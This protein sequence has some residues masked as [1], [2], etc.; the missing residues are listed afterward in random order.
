MSFKRRDPLP[1][2][3]PASRPCQPAF[4]PS[5]RRRRCRD[6]VRTKGQMGRRESSEAAWAVRER[7]ARSRTATTTPSFLYI[8]SPRARTNPSAWSVRRPACCLLLVLPPSKEVRPDPTL[9]ASARPDDYSHPR[10]YSCY[11]QPEGA[12]CPRP[13]VA[14]PLQ[15]TG[16][17][18]QARSS[19]RSLPSLVSATSSGRVR[20]VSQE[21]QQA[22]PQ[23]DGRQ[24]AWADPRAR[25]RPPSPRL[26][27]VAK[28]N[29]KFEPESASLALVPLVAAG[30]ARPL[31]VV[32]LPAAQSSE[33]RSSPCSPRPRPRRTS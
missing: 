28:A 3:P 9:L 33:M 25:L 29:A 4:A 32:P 23:T 10:P 22:G 12:P 17:D 13:R 19:T 2:E 15:Q 5:G 7:A 1:C 21:A 20:A 6:G 11:R 26:A 18:R 30:R 16:A 31:T 14:V 8:T 24:A 27:G